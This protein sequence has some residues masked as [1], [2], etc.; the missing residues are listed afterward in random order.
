MNILDNDIDIIKYSIKEVLLSFADEILS[1]KKVKQAICDIMN[2]CYKRSELR[3]QRYPS[4][5]C[6][7]EYKKGNGAVRKKMN[8][9]KEEGSDVSSLTKR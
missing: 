7:I 9:D 1:E 3:H 5:D 6:R 8:E 4:L 2:L